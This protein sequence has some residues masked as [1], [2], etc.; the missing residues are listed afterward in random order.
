MSS[1]TNSFSGLFNTP[2]AM[3]HY[4]QRSL[5]GWGLGA[6]QTRVVIEE[7]S[8]SDA[9]EEAAKGAILEKIM[10]GRQP[11]DLLLRCEIFP[12]TLWSFAS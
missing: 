2:K 12:V 5:V 4:S 8:P 6:W 10:K 3:L 9:H 1:G 11:T 7:D